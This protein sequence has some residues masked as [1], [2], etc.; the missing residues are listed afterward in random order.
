M[1]QNGRGR[2]LTSIKGFI[3]RIDGLSAGKD[4]RLFFRGHSNRDDYFIEPSVFRKSREDN[5]HKGKDVEHILFRELIT[6]NPSE[7]QG[8]TSTLERLA[9]MQHH[10]SPT[11]LLDITSNPLVSLYFACKNHDDKHAEVIVLRVKETEIKF[12]DSDTASCIANL[13]RMTKEDKDSLDLTLSVEAFN[14]DTQDEVSRLLHFI[15]EEKPYFRNKIIPSDLKRVLVVR[16]KLNSK[17]IL[18]QAGAFLLFGQ[19]GRIDDEPVAGVS[20]ERIIIDKSSKKTIRDKLDALN[21]N[22]GSLYLD[23]D[24]YA[25]YLKKKHKL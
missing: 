18:A 3:D 1:S 24:S 17:R 6:T 20:I 16:P 19:V 5:S 10:S 21:I 11:R 25:S 2:P 9:R 14:A 23:I 8:D 12:F 15:R 4:E 13:A 7:F 22:E